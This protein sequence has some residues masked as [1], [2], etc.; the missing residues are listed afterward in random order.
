MEDLGCF[1]T[2]GPFF[3]PLVRPVSLPP[4]NSPKPKFMLYTK[5]NPSK[6]YLLEST[7]RSLQNSQF[8]SSAKTMFFIHGFKFKLNPQD[9][10]FV[11]SSLIKNSIFTY[12]T[13]NEIR[14]TIISYVLYN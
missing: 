8:D 6:P 11:S 1:Y 12:L 7:P 14:K 9:T 10:Q 13:V 3:S 2:G 4:V 5:N